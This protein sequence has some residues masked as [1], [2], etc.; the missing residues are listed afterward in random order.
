MKSKVCPLEK[1]KGQ[2]TIKRDDGFLRY[3]LPT[4]IEENVRS[5]LR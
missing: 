5:N 4:K 2:G 3:I 1:R